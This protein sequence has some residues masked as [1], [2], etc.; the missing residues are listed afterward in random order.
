MAALAYDLL[1]HFQLFL[2][3]RW[4]EFNETWQ[5]A[6]SQHP[7]PGL[8]FSGWSEKQDS[9]PVLWLAE[10]F[11][12]SPMKPLNGIKRNLTESKF[13]TS[14]TKFVFLDLS[15]KQYGRPGL[16]LAETYFDFSSETAERNSAKLDRKQNLD[17]LYQVCVFRAEK[18]IKIATLANPSK[19]V[20]HCTQVHIIGPFGAS[21]L[22]IYLG[23]VRGVAPIHVYVWEH[24]VSLY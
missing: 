1:R 13:S 7:L 20:A 9:R 17:V 21:C 15:K 5:K 3:N 24:I 16:W 22:R 23:E 10:T 8:R 18:W 12:T 11:F 6:R 19:K 2:W 14:S 4:I